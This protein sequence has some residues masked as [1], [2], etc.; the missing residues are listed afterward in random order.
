MPT[1]ELFIAHIVG[2]LPEFKN[3]LERWP[4]HITIAPPFELP[5]QADTDLVIKCIKKCR[6]NL[7]IIKL[8]CGNIRSGAIPIEIG[9]EA[10]FGENNDIPVVEILDPSGELHKLH[11]YLIRQLG[12]VG[13]RFINHNPEWDGEN[14]SPHATMKSGERLNHPFFCTNVSLCEKSQSGKSIIDTINLYN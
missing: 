13:C 14:Y 2:N 8:N 4:L 7:G 6:E 10:M 9:N 1:S 5:I 11:S 3:N 12:N